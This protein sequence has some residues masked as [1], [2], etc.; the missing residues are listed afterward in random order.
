LNANP[1]HLS[2]DSAPPADGVPVSGATAADVV[3]VTGPA[4]GP[5]AE[6]AF[7]RI[8]FTAAWANILSQEFGGFRVLSLDDLTSAT[9]G[10]STLAIVPRNVTRA[11]GVAG[12][13]SLERFVRSG[14]IALIEMPT[15]PWESLVSVTVPASAYQATR[16]ITA[17]PGAV[18]RGRLRDD[19]IQTPMRTVLAP[20]HL[21]DVI[22]LDDI[23]VLMEVDGLPAFIRR[24]I[25]TGQVFALYF[26]LAQ[27]VTALQQ[28]VPETEWELL[29]PT[30]STPRG[31]SRTGCLVSDPDLHG[32]R[33]PWADVLE[34]QI[35]AVV[36]AARP[37][38]RVWLYPDA[39]PGAFAMTHT[40]E[41]SASS[42]DFMWSW[43]RAEN[44]PATVFAR[45]D[46]VEAI[47]E[48][49]QEMSALLLV[50]P[51]LDEA[52]IR[53]L[54]FLGFDPM[55][56]PLSLEDQ[57]EAFGR[58][59]D[60]SGEQLVTRLSGGLWDPEYG[61]TFGVL[62]GLGV[63][64]D[65]SYGIDR[66]RGVTDRSSGYRFGTGLP[67]QPIDRMGRLL[68]LLEIPTTLDDGI[69]TTEDW[70]E[71]L[72]NDAAS[73]YHELIVADWPAGT[74]TLSPRADVITG[75]R[76]SFE[77]ARR[78]GLWITDLAEF[79]RFWQL[80]SEVGVTT[81]FTHANRRLSI[82]VT[83]GEMRDRRDDPIRPSIAFEA[84][85]QGRPIQRVTVGGRDVPFMDMGTTG[86]GLFHLLQLPAGESRVEVTYQG[87]I[88]LQ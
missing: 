5:P 18:T 35:L 11:F 64:V 32:S 80:R 62:A 61:V 40:S 30:E 28:G 14:G 72:L 51:E 42:G 33:V 4:S 69:D 54:G 65:S 84:R 47:P 78:Q 63:A 3:L 83:N 22:G 15:A 41:P 27:A 2:A 16:R 45:A 38:A 57:I 49:A 76:R 44:V 71:I 70:L 67:F 20:V 17:F 8:D 74:M 7:E 52:P 50:P 25:G 82:R 58:A 23:D 6:P 31:L 88:E 36:T 60:S 10:E 75:W 39:R 55:V 29:R 53:H 66:C 37:M 48:S 79:A 56:Q 1:I 34:R 85:Y 46:D 81:E 24:R 19:V 68:P 13:D 59:A 21:A 9:L 43:E 26:D 73:T 77:R 86:D 87:P 12:V